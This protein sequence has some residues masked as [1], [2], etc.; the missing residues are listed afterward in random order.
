MRRINPV[1]QVAP[2]RY[3]AGHPV[4]EATRPKTKDHPKY[5]I[6]VQDGV[7]FPYSD[8]LARDPGFRPSDTLPPEHI[9]A[10]KDAIVR[11]E[12]VIAAK[13]AAQ[14][15]QDEQIRLKIAEQETRVTEARAAV[16]AQVPVTNAAEQYEMDVI[17]IANADRK[18]LN[19]IAKQLKVKIDGRQK[20][21]SIRAQ[22]RAAMEDRL[23]PETPESP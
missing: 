18:G 15:R 17:R 3:V 5:C 14:A 6:R 10:N 8:K 7:P 23:Q 19:D 22:L 11:D 1:H 2:V 13:R 21:D 4:P 12:M 20:I 9:R 16:M